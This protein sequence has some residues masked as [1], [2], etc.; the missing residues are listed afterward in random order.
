[1]NPIIIIAIIAQS[2]ISKASSMAGAITGFLITTGIFLW[3]LSLY[4]GGSGIIFFFV[5]LSE[6]VFIVLCLVWY[7][8]NIRRFISAR[9][10]AVARSSQPP[11]AI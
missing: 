11:E 8:F 9:K 1:M 7:G 10:V 6:T 2:F 5:P 4:S 3:G